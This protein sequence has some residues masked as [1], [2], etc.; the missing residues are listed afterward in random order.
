[1][2]PSWVCQFWWFCLISDWWS[3]R[4]NCSL[5]KT[6]RFLGWLLGSCRSNKIRCKSK[7]MLFCGFVYSICRQICCTWKEYY[8]PVKA[9]SW[10]GSNRQNRLF[11][12]FHDKFIFCRSNR[13]WFRSEFWNLVLTYSDAHQT[14]PDFDR[15][16]WK[17]REND[18]TLRH[19][20]SL[21]RLCFCCSN[22]SWSALTGEMWWAHLCK[23]IPRYE[24]LWF[25]E[26]LQKCL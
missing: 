7:M 15:C 24:I 14:K 17:S 6:R 23:R 12:G 21:K 11:F 1:M 18:D 19:R 22:R 10:F 13:P 3:C 9:I 25:F 8:F 2:I 26:L 20:I 4:D 5:C 16:A